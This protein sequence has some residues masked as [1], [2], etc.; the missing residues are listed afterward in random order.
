MPSRNITSGLNTPY[1]IFATSN[2]DVFIDNGNSNSRVD[3]WTLSGLNS[4]TMSVRD[5]CYDLFIDIAYNLY[6]SVNSKHQVMMK[7]LDSNSDMWIIAGGTDCSGSASNQLNAPR[8]IY[9]DESL[10]LYVA[11]CSNNR[12]QKFPSQELNAITV[13]GS[14]AAG[15]I[16]LSCPSDVALDADGYLFVVD[17]T[18]HRI[19]GSSSTGFRCI[20]GCAGSYGAT[21]YQLN[22]PS[23][24]SFDNYGNIFVTD[25][26][27]NRIQKFILIPKSTYS[28]YFIE[29]HM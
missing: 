23:T 1:S 25:N 12:V 22:T 6:C 18:N 29:V 8:G 10:N 24:M 17:S 14:S 13:V 21:S 11:D 5:A 15:T 28:E 26:G 27:N 3:K 2:G 9:V 4:T 19:I 7:S 20:V 16:S